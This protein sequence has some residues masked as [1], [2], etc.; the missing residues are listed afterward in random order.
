MLPTS[1]DIMWC[2]TTIVSFSINMS[3]L[4]IF[5]GVGFHPINEVLD[6]LQT[7]H[8]LKFALF[9]VQD[10]MNWDYVYHIIIKMGVIVMFNHNRPQLQM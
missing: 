3:Y 1:K 4:D 2:G 9:Y 8:L 5:F 10:K 7:F 6:S